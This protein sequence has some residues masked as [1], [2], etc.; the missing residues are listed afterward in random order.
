MLHAGIGRLPRFD[1]L[2]ACNRPI[3]TRIRLGRG[4]RVSTPCSLAGTSHPSPGSKQPPCNMTTV[5]TRATLGA[6]PDFWNSL[7]PSRENMGVCDNYKRIITRARNVCSKYELRYS[8]SSIL[9][10]CQ[11]QPA[12]AEQMRGAIRWR[13]SELHASIIQALGIPG[14]SS[15]RAVMQLLESPSS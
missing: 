10:V 15:H 9:P 12:E 7:L 6:F 11:I 8:I 5:N 4:T 13:C 3:L 2:D 14:K 1:D